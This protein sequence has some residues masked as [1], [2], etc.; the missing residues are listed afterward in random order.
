MRLID[1][2]VLR[3]T[4][5]VEKKRIFKDR[6]MK[7]ITVIKEVYLK[8]EIEN[9]LTIEA[10]PVV[11]G[12]WIDA[13]QYVD[14][15]GLRYTQVRCSLCGRYEDEREP[16][17]NCGA[18]MRKEKEVMPAKFNENGCPFDYPCLDDYTDCYCNAKMDGK[19][20]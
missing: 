18:D 9:A 17:C 1:A 4:Q 11:H 6:K 14:E 2:D 15:D 8:E 20:V 10:A 7:S 13:E 12:E 3:S 5:I 19:A 16:Y